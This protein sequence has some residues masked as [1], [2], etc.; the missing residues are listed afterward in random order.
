[1]KNNQ[2]LPH[3]G[4]R[5][6]K[7]PRQRKFSKIAYDERKRRDEKESNKKAREQRPRQ[8]CALSSVAANF[9]GVKCRGSE[10]IPGVVRRQARVSD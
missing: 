1:M 8:C 2:Y 10:T 6:G 4:R 7:V 3:S 5:K 9:L